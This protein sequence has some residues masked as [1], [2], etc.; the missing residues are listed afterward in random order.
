MAGKTLGNT[1][2]VVK[3]SDAVPACDGTQVNGLMLDNAVT[4]SV[5]ATSGCEVTNT[6]EAVPELLG[7]TNDVAGSV[8]TCVDGRTFTSDMGCAK[9]EAMMGMF[10]KKTSDCTPVGVGVPL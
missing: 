1:V 7:S 4:F 3:P 10:T 9:A 5:T 2:L 6:A 8:F